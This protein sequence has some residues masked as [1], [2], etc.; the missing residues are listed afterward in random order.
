MAAVSDSDDLLAGYAVA[1][2][3]RSYD[4]PHKFDIETQ[5]DAFSWLCDRIGR[6]R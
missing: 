2:S 4:G 1:Y 6:V 5:Q 3:R